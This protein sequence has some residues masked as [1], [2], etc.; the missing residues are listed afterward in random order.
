MKKLKSTAI[1]YVLTL[2]IISATI[3]LIIELQNDNIMNILEYV[4]DNITW[5]LFLLGLIATIFIFIRDKLKHYK[6]DLKHYQEEI[7][8]EIAHL[9]HDLSVDINDSKGDLSRGID[10]LRND[11]NN[12][13]NN[14]FTIIKTWQSRDIDQFNEFARELRKNGV[15][16]RQFKPTKSEMELLKRLSQIES[17]E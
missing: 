12:D 3:W 11:I 6:E 16:V 7:K 14:V 9:K 17:K 8:N 5:I 10:N 15:N 4:W 1:L 2:D 13:I